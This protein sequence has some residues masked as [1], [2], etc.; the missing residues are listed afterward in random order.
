MRTDSAGRDF[1]DMSGVMETAREAVG[2]ES[3]LSGED[4]PPFFAEVEARGAGPGD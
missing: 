3:P 1:T 4:L 2:E